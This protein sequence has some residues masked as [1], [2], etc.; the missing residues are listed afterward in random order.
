MRQNPKATTLLGSAKEVRK[1]KCLEGTKGLLEKWAPGLAY[2][3]GILSIAWPA[4]ALAARAAG[5]ALPWDGPLTTLQALLEDWL[6]L[7]GVR[8]VPHQRKALWRA[9]TLV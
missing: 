8:I 1:M 6:E 4:R 9:L 7:Q 3:F 5:G 2:A